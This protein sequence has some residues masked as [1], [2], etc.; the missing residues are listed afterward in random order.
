VNARATL[1]NA[2]DAK[3]MGFDARFI[4][5]AQPRFTPIAESVSR[6]PSIRIEL[7]LM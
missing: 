6:P 1:A 4:R 5:W 3:F 7:P 2:F